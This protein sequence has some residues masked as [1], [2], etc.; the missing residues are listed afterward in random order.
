MFELSTKIKTRSADEV[1]LEEVMSVL[2][3]SIVAGSDLGFS[4]G[5]EG[6]DKVIVVLVN[7]F[8]VPRS[9][10][11]LPASNT[12]LGVSSRGGERTMGSGK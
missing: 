12:D 1:V 8:I 2:D 11:A 6:F 7:V 4:G 5:D 9:S 10:L 3:C